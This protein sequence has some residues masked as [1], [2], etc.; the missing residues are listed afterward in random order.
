[1]TKLHVSPLHAGLAAALAI[2]LPLRAA[3]VIHSASTTGSTNWS[4]ATWTPTVSDWSTTAGDVAQFGGNG[5]YTIDT[6]ITVGSVKLNNRNGDW[7]L[8]SNGGNT[9]TLDGT[10][11]SAVNQGFG[12]AGVASLLNANGNTSVGSSRKLNLGNSTAGL[13]LSMAS[14]LDIGVAAGAGQGVTTYG[15]IT[16]TSGSAK[17]LTIRANS[18]AGSNPSTNAG[19]I[20][21][22]AI[23]ASGSGIAIVNAG[24]GSGNITLAGALGANVTSLAQNSSTSNLTISVANPGFAGTTSVTAG[25]LTLSGTGNNTLGTSTLSI[26]GGTLNLGGKSVTNTLTSITGGTLSNGTITNDGGNFDVQAGTISAKLSGTNGLIKSTAG[27]ATLSGSGTNYGGGTTVN[28]GTLAY[29]TAFTLSG[30]NAFGGLT[31]ASSTAGADY[32]QITSSAAFTYGGSLTF[33]FTAPTTAGATYDFFNVG[34]SGGAFTGVSVAGSYKGGFAETTL[35]SKIWELS[36]GGLK[37]TFTADGGANDGILA[38]AAAAV[39]EPSAFAALAGL[40]GVACVGL[41]RRRA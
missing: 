11:L 7:T 3:D 2:A 40:A 13:A 20:I 17:T 35:G 26:S 1:M 23:G 28:G 8:L 31:G 15:T 5:S 18:T 6:N 21:N 14:H 30:A 16:N 32:G 41:R 38:V 4:A 34:A 29:T 10:G 36:T 37:F 12:N 27:L 19:V 24:T 33:N 22:S 9:L 39:P 25:N